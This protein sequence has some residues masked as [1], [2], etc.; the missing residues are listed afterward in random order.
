MK[1]ESERHK[2]HKDSD[3]C[4]DSGEDRYHPEWAVKKTPLEKG[5]I[6]GIRS[7]CSKCLESWW[8]PELTEEKFQED[9]K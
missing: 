4:T 2:T 5:G 3:F 8:T 1:Q 6:K 9:W 7:V